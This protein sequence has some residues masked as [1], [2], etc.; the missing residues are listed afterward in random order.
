M[1]ETAAVNSVGTREPPT[2]PLDTCATDCARESGLA[3]LGPAWACR[4]DLG[5]SPRFAKAEDQ[6]HS[7]SRSIKS[8]GSLSPTIYC[9]SRTVCARA[10][11]SDHP[12]LG[13]SAPQARISGLSCSGSPSSGRP[14]HSGI[15]GA[16]HVTGSE[17]LGPAGHEPVPPVPG[18]LDDA[19]GDR[20]F[21]AWRRSPVQHFVFPGSK[22]GRHV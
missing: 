8:S 13:G 19:S 1:R 4:S 12:I 18:C 16:E 2:P 20:C 21:P 6:P 15:A 3:P 9:S 5:G 10:T 17:E 22:R 11:T 7:V 14:A